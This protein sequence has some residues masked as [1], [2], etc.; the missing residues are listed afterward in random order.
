MQHRRF[1]IN[2]P[3]FFADVADHNMYLCMHSVLLL[4]PLANHSLLLVPSFIPISADWFSS[5]WRK[6]LLLHGHN[7]Y[8]VGGA[9]PTPPAPTVRF[10]CGAQ[11][12]LSWY[13]FGWCRCCCGRE[14]LSTSQYPF[15]Y[16][17]R[18]WQTATA[19]CAGMPCWNLPRQLCTNFSS[20]PKS[21]SDLTEIIISRWLG[22]CYNGSVISGCPVLEVTTGASEENRIDRKSPPRKTL[23]D[24]LSYACESRKPLNIKGFRQKENAR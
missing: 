18:F 12:R 19:D 6:I 10:F 20:A 14:Y 1:L 17:R 9:L 23:Q 11:C 21:F 7:S 2:S 22:Q 5:A 24:G 8:Y 4:F 15:P 16:R 3:L 13:K